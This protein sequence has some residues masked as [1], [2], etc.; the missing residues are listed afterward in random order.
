MLYNKVT[1]NPLTAPCELVIQFLL[2][3]PRRCDVIVERRL[4]GVQF[5]LFL[6]HRRH[7]ISQLYAVRESYHVHRMTLYYGVPISEDNEGMHSGC[8]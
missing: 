4:E 1:N 2:Q 5:A 8:N 3:L 7:A 6:V